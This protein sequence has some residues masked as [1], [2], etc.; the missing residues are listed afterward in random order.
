MNN[1]YEYLTQF[2]RAAKKAKWPKERI[3][4]VLTEA[5]S[6]NYENALC[7]LHAALDQIEGVWSE[8][9]QSERS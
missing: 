3:E 6:G 4:A 5:R 9:I 2:C 8:Q 1:I 7:V